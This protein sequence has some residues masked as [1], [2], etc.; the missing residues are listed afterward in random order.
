ME[1]NPQKEKLEEERGDEE[2]VS[3]CFHT[4]KLGKGSILYL[5][6]FVQ[7]R[8]VFESV[9]FFNQLIKRRAKMAVVVERKDEGMFIAN[10]TGFSKKRKGHCVK[11]VAEPFVLCE[12]RTGV[13]VL[14][15]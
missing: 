15:D 1:G 13:F 11:V 2:G 14:G 7:E 5:R 9:L 12:N 10:S 8:K 4:G 6:Y 3:H